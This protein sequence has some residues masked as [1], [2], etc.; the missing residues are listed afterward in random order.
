MTHLQALRAAFLEMTGIRADARWGAKRLAEEVAILEGIQ[1]QRKLKEAEAKAEQERK[2]AE[3]DARIAA[4]GS[5][6]QFCDR[7]FTRELE[8][9][10]DQLAYVCRRAQ[11][12]IE[13]AEKALAEFA[14]K[15]AQDPAYALSWGTRSFEHAAKLKVAQWLR[16]GVIEAGATLEALRSEATREAMR[17]ARSPERST[18]PT[19]NLMSQC[20]TAA[21]AEMVE[22]LSGN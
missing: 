1:R 21:W 16:T 12:D 8:G 20:M 6:E 7:A 10:E 19:S 11:H 9:D 5:W 15:L 14:A 2:Q 3:R 18:S 17:G 22:R 13:S 4:R